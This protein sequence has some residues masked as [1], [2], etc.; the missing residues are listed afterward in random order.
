MKLIYERN[1][2]NG[3]SDLIKRL[4]LELRQNKNVLWLVSGG[5]NIQSAV[6]VMSNIPNELQ[7]QLTIL[8]VDERFGKVGHEDSNYQQL[9]DAGFNCGD[10]ILLNILEP[11]LSIEQTDER[12]KSLA[13]QAF[14]EADVVIA[15]LGIGVDGHIAGILP[16]SLASKESRKYVSSYD[17]DSFQ[18]ITLT[19]PA[20]RKIRAAYVYAYGQSK[21]DALTSL[22]SEI[23]NPEI[24]PAQILK[25]LPEAYVYNDSI[26]T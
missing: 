3:L 21:A 22:I 17:S 5:S 12:F 6:K 18:R 11:N 14:E 24:Q 4:K 23:I 19:F 9:L 7:M 1:I 15:I 25:E 2:D 8:P 10:A 16:E 13:G 26:E 20:L